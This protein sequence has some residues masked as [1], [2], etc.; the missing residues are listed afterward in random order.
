MLFI[1]SAILTWTLKDTISAATDLGMLVITVVSV[2]CAFMAYRH[3]KKRSKKETACKLAK[4][5]AENIIT[6][7]GPIEFVFSDSGINEYT[8]ELFKIDEISAFDIG[9]LEGLLAKKGVDAEETKRKMKDINPLS[10]LIYSLY[11][12]GSIRS[13]IDIVEHILEFVS[14]E[15]GDERFPFE[16]K[17]KE[18][19]VSKFWADVSNLLNEL[20]WFSMNCRYGIADEEILYQSLHQSFLSDI[21]ILYYRICEYNVSNEDKVYT[22]IIWLF[23]RWRDRFLEI[24][25]EAEQK[26]ELYQKRLIP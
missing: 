3:Q 14:K 2:L 19:L 22:N 18:Y 21:F 7:M 13:Q 10:T 5:Y 15:G 23:R 17:N 26:K 24:K 11:S 16:I 12:E 9:E 1:S 4:Y 8:K 20:E 6:K 25:R